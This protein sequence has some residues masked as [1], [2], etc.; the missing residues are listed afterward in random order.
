MDAAASGRII[1]AI[2]EIYRELE[3][4]DDTPF[5]WLKARR[6]MIADL[7]TMVQQHVTEIRAQPQA[8]RYAEKWILWTSLCDCAGS[9]SWALRRDRGQAVRRTCKA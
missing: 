7:A 5:Q 2:D 9:S 8:D 6:A 1:L 4:K 3:K